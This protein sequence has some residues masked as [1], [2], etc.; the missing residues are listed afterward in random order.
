MSSFPRLEELVGSVQ[1][2]VSLPEV[3]YRL[4]E[5]IDD[6]DGCV[7]DIAVIISSDPDLT[8]RLLALVNSSLY[9]FPAQ[10]DTVSRAV[11]LVGTRQLR[12][13]ALATLVVRRFSGLPLGIVDMESFWRHSLGVAVVSRAIATWR[14]ERNVERFFVIGLLHD[15]GRLV[16]LLKQPQAMHELLL[17]AREEGQSL[18]RLERE[19][20]GYDHA[21]VGGRLLS[22]WGMPAAMVSAVG[23]HHAP[24][25]RATFGLDACVAHLAD[26]TVNA[27]EWGSSGQPLVPTLNVGAWQALALDTSAIGE[28]I[29]R[30]KQQY[31]DSTSLF[32]L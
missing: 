2:L 15:L 23:G 11:T 10:V 19:T 8:L 7:D 13:L 28:L 9:A 29:K 4:E 20:F 27:L 18:Y 26:L 16:L 17:Q 32:L 12:D 31:Q 30:S 22:D 3:Y 21:D 5:A 24:D 1:Q 25:P 14:R 6:P